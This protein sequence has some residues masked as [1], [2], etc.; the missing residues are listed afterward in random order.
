MPVL[1]STSSVPSRVTS[2]RQTRERQLKSKPGS[3]S[4]QASIM[5]QFMPCKE[6][7]RTLSTSSQ[8][9]I[10]PPRSGVRS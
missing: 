1:S 8:S 10:G 6:T 4:N 5:A 2:S 3:V 9:V 7:P